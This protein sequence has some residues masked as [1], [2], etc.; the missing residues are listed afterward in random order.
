MQWIVPATAANTPI[1]IAWF[2]SE[3]S[4]AFNSTRP[5]ISASEAM[6][7]R[8]PA[9]P[10]ANSMSPIEGFIRLRHH[11]YWRA[12][13][14][15]PLKSHR[16]MRRRAGPKIKGRATSLFLAR[17]PEAVPGHSPPRND[18]ARSATGRY[19]TRRSDSA[20]MKP[21]LWIYVSIC[22]NGAKGLMALSRVG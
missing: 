11:G 8:K 12:R 17:P 3:R 6:M 15:L 13:P 2:T 7:A 1:P 16:A 22:S 20:P 4:V 10:I 19:A 21:R 18:H 5:A 9:P 14:W